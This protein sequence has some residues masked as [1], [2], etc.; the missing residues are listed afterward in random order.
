MFVYK[1]PRVIRHFNIKHDSFVLYDLKD[2]LNALD[3]TFE[4]FKWLCILSGTDYHKYY[5]KKINIFC[6][7]KKFKKYNKI[8]TDLDY[9]NWMIDNNYIPLNEDYKQIYNMFNIEKKKLKIYLLQMDF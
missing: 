5:N 4:N 3:M 1:C 9:Y 2:I 7:Y 8:K 6:N